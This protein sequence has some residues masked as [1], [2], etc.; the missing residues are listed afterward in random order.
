MILIVDDSEMIIE[1]V[2]AMLEENNM[3]DIFSARSAKEAFE[4]IQDNVP[5]IIL[6]DIQMPGMTGVEALPIIKKKCPDAKVIM[7]T[8]NAEPYYKE[9]CERLGADYFADKSVDFD[10]IPE[11][12]SAIQ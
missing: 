10:R 2:R 7:L 6:L 8:N 11:I 12:I 9:V 3:S 4:L 1:Y 5:E